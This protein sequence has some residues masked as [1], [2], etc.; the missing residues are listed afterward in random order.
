MKVV[1]AS[2]K[3]E[4]LEKIERLEEGHDE[5]YISLRPTQEIVER[6]VE[7]TDAI[8]KIKCPKSLYFQVGKKVN[9]KL[10]KHGIELEPGEYS[11]GR[12][13]KYSEEEIER[14]LELREK[15]CSVQDI[16]EDM[17]VPVRTIYYY[18]NKGIND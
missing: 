11:P 4:L 5:L 1:R 7:Q 12:P 6:I 13:R 15:G 9:D 2:N 17:D 10:Q 18:L 3:E 16:S 8:E 14:I